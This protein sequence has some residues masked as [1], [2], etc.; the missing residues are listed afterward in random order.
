MTVAPRH[1]L[2]FG[3]WVRRPLG[4]L[5]AAAAVVAA[6]TAVYQAAASGP[7]G[8]AVQTA[9]LWVDTNGGTCSRNAIPQ[10]YDD[11]G[12]CGSLDAAN[13]VCQNG[14]TVLVKGGTYGA[15]TVSGGN[16]RTSP[17]LIAIAEG[18]TATL[19]GGLNFSG[20][21]QVSVD[22]GGSRNGVNARLVTAAMGDDDNPLVPNNQ[23]PAN[24]NSGSRNV[25]LDGADFGGWSMVDSQNVIYRNNDIGPCDSYDAQD[26]GARGLAYC[27]NGSIEYCEVAE[28][29]CAGYNQGHLIEGNLVHDFGCSPS[30]YNG[31]GS[32]DCH[33]E[34]MYVSY[35]KALTIRGNTFVN[36]S[37]GGNIF[38]T[39]SDGGGSFDADFGFENYTMESNVF[40]RSCSN[41][42]TP[43]GGRLDNASGFGH[44]NIYPGND[45]TNVK[46]RF[47]T[48]LGGSGFDMDN[49]CTMGSPGVTFTG[50]IRNGS[51][52]ACGTIWP[53]DPTFEYEIYYKYGGTCAGTGNT[54]LGIGWDLSAVVVSDSD[55]APNAHLAGVAGST[56]A[57]DYVPTAAGC[58]PSDLDGDARPQDA[59]CDA[60]AD[61]R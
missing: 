15:Q 24:A 55:T 39:F 48:F 33:W 6:G 32:D 30:F 31:Q 20:A 23:F 10:E 16:D 46:I 9:H 2:F 57:D 54:N 12:A 19:D 22:G 59:A 43:C 21:L 61:E 11:A 28:I 44:C 53:V 38:H 1:G 14:E 36:C 47:N 51:T 26:P 5:L 13:D 7:G 42:S 56:D 50:N 37:N 35:A 8:G 34:C 4:A 58:A 17:C 52:V 25:T 45:F 60:G 27:D 29:G 49:A 40:T 18:E 41:S 3:S